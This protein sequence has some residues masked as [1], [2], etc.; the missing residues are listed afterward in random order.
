MVQ[1]E[2][3]QFSIEVMLDYVFAIAACMFC[4]PKFAILD[5]RSWILHEMKPKHILSRVPLTLCEEITVATQRFK[6]LGFS[7]IIHH[8]GFL[9][10]F[11]H[12]LRNIF[13][14]HVFKHRLNCFVTFS[15]RFELTFFVVTSVLVTLMFSHC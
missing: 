9:H 1:N 13:F 10:V 8:A 7:H 12:I 3:F 6:V 15:P 11:N 2:Q 14:S 4:R 5:P